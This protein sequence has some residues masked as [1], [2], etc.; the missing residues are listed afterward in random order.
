MLFPHYTYCN[1]SLK[2]MK[3]FGHYYVAPKLSPSWCHVMKC[4]CCDCKDVREM[5]AVTDGGVL[6]HTGMHWTS[7]LCLMADQTTLSR[8]IDVKQP[9]LSSTLKESVAPFWWS[10]FSDIRLNLIDAASTLCFS[11]SRR[12]TCCMGVLDLCQDGVGLSQSK[13]SEQL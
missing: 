6:E 2:H 7:R 5:H 11:Q 4:F 12:S 8:Q 10:L 9:T 3:L 13:E 1:A